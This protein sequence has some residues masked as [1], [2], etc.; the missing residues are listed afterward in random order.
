MMIDEETRKELVRYLQEKIPA[1]G[2]VRLLTFT[3]NNDGKNCQYCDQVRQLAEELASIAKGKVLVDNHQMYE[4]NLLVE[5][6]RVRRIPATVVT[7]MRGNFSM[8]FY[9]IPAGYEF[10]ALLEDIVD[11]ASGAPR[12]KEDTVR[13]LLK[14]EKPIHIQVFVTPTCPY[15]PRAVRMAHQFSMVNPD[16]IDSEMIES[17]EFPE[18]A[19]KYSVMAVPKVVINDRVE[20]EGALPEP[21]FLYKVMEATRVS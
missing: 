1:E 6:F 3:S 9:G 12:L 11:A 7:D 8:K 16:N 20:F 17:M 15:C 18:L 21:V 10:S 14:I 5:R 13:V 19:E 4:S 2:K